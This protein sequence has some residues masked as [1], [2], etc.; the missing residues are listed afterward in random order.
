MR[1]R[2]IILIQPKVGSWEFIQDVP[3]LPLALLYISALVETKYEIQII[4]Q[5]LDKE[6]SA[7]LKR[8]LNGDVL[9]VGITTM[10]G[11]QISYALEAS[12]V[13]KQNS[14]A[15]V[16][17][18]G[19]HPSILPL[20]TV[21]HPLVDIVVVGEGDIVFHDLVCALNNNETCGSIPGLWFKDKGNVINSMP[22]AIQDINALPHIPYHLIRIEDY[23]G[24][25]REGRRKFPIKTSRG[26]PYQCTFCHQTS[27]Y[28]RSWRALNAEK[29]LDEIEKLKHNNNIQHFQILDDN[30]FVDTGRSHAILQGIAD[31]KMD[32]VY[33][34]NGTRVTD[35]LRMKDE[36]LQLLSKTGCYELQIG[37][38]S[39]SQRVLEHMKKGVKIEQIFEAN[40]KLRQYNIPRYYEL[41]SGFRDETEDDLLQTANV[42]LEL[43]KGDRNVFFSP[44]E[45]LTP[46][47]GTEVY[48]QAISAG[49]K[50]PSQLD[51]WS[52]YQWSNAKLPWLTDS[53]QKCLQSLHLFP[54]LISCENKTLRSP[55]M[56]IFYKIYRPWARFRVQRLYFGFLFESFLFNFIAK[57]RS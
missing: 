8:A 42:I 38:E 34:I 10:T 19:I 25:D 55:L 1:K 14:S 47:P 39:G 48:E 16:V 31:R 51:E 50:F 56:K 43:S 21:Q 36:T 35:I 13:V 9:C 3:M 15:P 41:V 52:G 30:F 44:I 46:Y 18:G 12:K 27:S 29:V 4:D 17:W 11:P 54:T 40:R 5:R 49:M 6:W 23:I 20:Q 45:C 37:L 2:K 33:T 22:K 57:L 24:I 7:T 26:C 53:R 32:I 28:R